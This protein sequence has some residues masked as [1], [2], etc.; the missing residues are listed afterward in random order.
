MTSNPILGAGIAILLATVA[1]SASSVQLNVPLD[2]ASYNFPLGN[3]GGGLAATVNGAN[4]ETLCIDYFNDINPFSQY[5]ANLTQLSTTANLSDTRFGGVSGSGWTQFTTL[6]ST[7]DT[8]F[9]SGAGSTALARYA[10]AAYLVSLYNQS[11]GGTTAN[12]D[13]QD[14]IWTIMDPV[15]QGSV[16]DPGYNG[17]SYVEQAA[18]WYMNMDTSGNLAALNSF[19]SGFDVVSDST[20]TFSNGIGVGGFQEQ[21]IDPPAAPAPEPRSVA[22]VA[23]GF[24]AMGAFLRRK[25]RRCGVH[26]AN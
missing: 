15:S 17:T 8:F 25:I 7:D 11:A 26:A 18:T 20:M 23:I 10:M 5:T 19:L 4:A 3:G 13:I 1:A 24:L 9:N 21:M 22:I 14:A 12:N 6:G 2:T 16:S